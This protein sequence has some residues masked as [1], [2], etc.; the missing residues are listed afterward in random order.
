MQIAAGDMA[1]LI[2]GLLLLGGGVFNSW[3][4]LRDGSIRPV[5]R[6]VERSENPILFWVFIAVF[7]GISAA[8]VIFALGGMAHVHTYVD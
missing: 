5:W 6:D 1:E 7:V 2:F 4:A 8:G 3:S